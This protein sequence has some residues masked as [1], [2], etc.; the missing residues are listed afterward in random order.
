M[1]GISLFA[2]L[3]YYFC[4]SLLERFVVGLPGAP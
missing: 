1:I 2:G 3:G 4:Y